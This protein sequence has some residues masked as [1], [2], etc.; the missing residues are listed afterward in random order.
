L[1]IGSVVVLNFRDLR[2]IRA[3]ART[4]RVPGSV[5]H[6]ANCLR[7]AWIGFFVPAAFISVLGYPHLYYLTALTVSLRRIAREQEELPARAPERASV[8]P[9]R[10]GPSGRSRL[11]EPGPRA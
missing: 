8:V 7:Y 5:G 11:P 4:G 9:G 3:L 1:L 2:Q 10:P 6:L